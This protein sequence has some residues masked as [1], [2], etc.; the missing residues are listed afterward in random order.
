MEA[1]QVDGSLAIDVHSEP[2]HNLNCSASSAAFKQLYKAVAEDNL[3]AVKAILGHA[4]QDQRAAWLKQ[5]SSDALTVSYRSL[6]DSACQRV[7]GRITHLCI[8]LPSAAARALSPTSL[9]WAPT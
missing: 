5:K 9:T 2:P 1:R 4:P 8:T 6:L 7:V 3:E